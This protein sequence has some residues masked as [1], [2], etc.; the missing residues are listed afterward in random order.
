MWQLQ[1][2]SVLPAQQ[3]GIKA[4]GAASSPGYGFMLAIRVA[5]V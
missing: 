4:T 1:T 3:C 2:S 5:L